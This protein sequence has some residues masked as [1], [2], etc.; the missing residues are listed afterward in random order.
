MDEWSHSES[1]KAR[2]GNSS[3]KFEGPEDLGNVDSTQE[4]W[5]GPCMEYH[6]KHASV[7]VKCMQ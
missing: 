3:N 2:A 6:L 4:L 7:T 1:N 5:L